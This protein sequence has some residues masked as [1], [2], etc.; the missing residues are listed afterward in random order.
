MHKDL[1]LGFEANV[2]ASDAGRLVH[3]LA[4]VCELARFL[5]GALTPQILLKEG[6]IHVAGA[7]LGVIKS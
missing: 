6:L 3:I 2:V 1:R 4:Q 5:A 7:I